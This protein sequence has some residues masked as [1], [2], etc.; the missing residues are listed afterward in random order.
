MS[1]MIGDIDIPS[2]NFR[3]EEGVIKVTGE[4]HLLSPN[5]TILAK[6]GFNGGYGEQVKISMSPDTQAHLNAFVAEF[7]NDLKKTLGFGA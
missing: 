3:R 1:L 5:K 4:Y 2:I 6:Q 7:N